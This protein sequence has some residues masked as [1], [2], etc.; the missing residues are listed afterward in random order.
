MNRFFTLV[1]LLNTLIPFC[2]KLSGQSEAVLS[3]LEISNKEI[4]N[5]L[6]EKLK[7]TTIC[8]WKNDAKTCLSL[9]FDDNN[10]SHNQI[11]RILDA[12]GYKGT[13]VVIAGSMYKD[14]IREMIKDGHE[15]GSH[16]YNHPDF[17]T[18]DSSQIEY[19]LSYSKALIETTFGINCLTFAEPGHLR[20][21][22]SKRIAIRNYLF[23][24]DY[25]EYS[26]VLRVNW[27]FSQLASGSITLPALAKEIRGAMKTGRMFVL[28]GHGL[29][30]EG[31]VPSTPEAMNTTLDTIKQYS[32]R[33]DIW[34]A[35]MREA[36]LYEDLYHEIV[37]DKKLSGDTLTV[38][39]KNYLKEKYNLI[40]S[41]LVC[42]KISKTLA[43]SISG[44]SDNI[45]IKEAT[46]D[47]I[48]TVDL[49]KDTT[50][51]IILNLPPIAHAGEDISVDENSN[52]I[53]DASASYD[54]EGNPIT[55]KWIAPS[56]ITLS[57][58][59]SV[60]TTFFA[61]EVTKDATYTFSLIVSDGPLTS[62]I[63]QI[64]VTVKQ[65]NKAPVAKVNKNI[66]VFEQAWV[67][68]DGSGSSDKDGDKLNYEWVTPKGLD[69]Y[70]LKSAFPYFQAPYV[71]E[72]TPLRFGLIVSDGKLKSDT[73][74][75]T[76]TVKKLN[77]YFNSTYSFVDSKPFEYTNKMYIDVMSASVNGLELGWGDE[78]AAFDGDVCVGANTIRNK[79]PN[80]SL[81]RIVAFGD[82]GN[83]NGFKDGNSIQFRIYDSS[84]RREFS[85]IDVFYRY[86]E[87]SLRSNVL[88]QSGITKAVDLLVLTTDI[89]NKKVD[90][91]FKIK[92][93]PN[94][95]ISE[96]NIDI[97]SSSNQPVKVELYNALGQSVNSI[98]NGM[99]EGQKNI[100]VKDLDSSLPAGIYFLKVNAQNFKIIH[101]NF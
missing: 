67:P 61:P 20:T 13:F 85:S 9:S 91:T 76:V 69:V 60:K 57:S 74:W 62:T 59:D 29:G 78:I 54:I 68:L 31:Y 47:F 21:D 79:T 51:Q 22:Q 5:A 100:K 84:R 2:P 19:Q 75:T 24:R 33:G 17:T 37:F 28:S 97:E 101:K 89:V 49:K 32:D 1:I 30:T 88:F 7:L 65:V 27:A 42:F 48:L 87:V 35:P 44:L 39:F 66:E 25:S 6:S 26:D 46:N 11:A 10:L 43:S 81:L 38:F 94:P 63:D 36:A 15:I 73:T 80:S 55:Y 16:S 8:K 40:D 99:V 70:E 90:P 14:S 41:S 56:S 77:G 71:D 58:T 86:S 50:Y 34:V 45:K 12:H 83:G 3:K 64:N 4:T 53:L 23:F 92:T 52:V 98:Y 96:F 18:L 95:F 72:K 82:D 93:Y